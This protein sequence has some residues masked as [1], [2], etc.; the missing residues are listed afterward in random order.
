M[1]SWFEIYVLSIIYISLVIST[2]FMLVFLDNSK[3]LKNPKPNRLPLVS[4][5]VPAFNEKDNIQKTLASLTKLDYPKNKLEIIVVDDG[6]TDNTYELAQQF[7]KEKQK[8]FKGKI[9]LLIKKN[10]G[11]GSA[12][13]LGLKH[14]T[15]E[16]IASMDADSIVTPSALKKMLGYFNQK[17]VMAV[18]PAM[19][20]YQPKTYL[21]K[22]Q[23]V[24]YLIGIYLRK[25]YA[26]LNSLYI[27]PGPFSLYRKCFFDK[28][29]GYDEKN[30]TED[31]EIGLR[32]Q[33][34]GYQIE[35]SID[36]SVYTQAPKNFKEL[37][38]Q[39][40]R[41]YLGF[42][43]NMKEYHH[44]LLLK[45][46]AL[47]S[48]ILPIAFLS[49]AL[50]IITT[51]VMLLRFLIININKLIDLS[52]VNFDIFTMLKGIR[53]SRYLD[54]FYIFNDLTFFAALMLFLS[55]S[56]V[57]IAKKFSFERETIKIGYIYYLLFYLPMYTYWWFR[58][59]YFI[60]TK[61]QV[62]WRKKLQHE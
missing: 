32:I 22:F 34:K 46:Q 23:M 31:M 30:L 38:Q 42:L 29:G 24:E 59:F 13:N 20:V 33:S 25:A 48:I 14:A 1:Y 61:K 39:R 9:L 54:S 58:V 2:F 36:A 6:S 51:L 7:A 60:A 4:I 57:L 27:A 28:Y 3:F 10:G 56:I 37:A 45:N 55:I 35:N 19:K 52:I 11:K 15:G 41:W 21:Q 44:L 40:T 26:Y 53:L 47:G 18:T 17:D 49:V 12:M 62:I 5:I 16:I 8:T 50:A 43:H